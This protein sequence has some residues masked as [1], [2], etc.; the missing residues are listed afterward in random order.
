MCLI[1]PQAVPPPDPK[2]TRVIV[3]MFRASAARC[4]LVVLGAGQ[5]KEEAEHDGEEDRRGEIKKG[6][7]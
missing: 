1:R 5:D 6:V 4:W 2:P 3:V 7:G